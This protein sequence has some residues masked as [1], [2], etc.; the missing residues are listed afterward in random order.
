VVK[1]ADDVM[2][3]AQLAAI[4]E[5]SATPKPGNVHRGADHLPTRF[6]HFLAGS[7]AI[8]T[9]MREAARRGQRAAAGR[10]R[11]SQIGIGN[12]TKKAVT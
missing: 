9:S 7:V 5:V 12:L 4:L 11:Y 3:A 6:E 8:G 10:M 2:E 1:T